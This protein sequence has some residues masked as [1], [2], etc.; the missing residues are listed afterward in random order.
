MPPGPFTINDLY[1]AGNGG[2][3]QVDIKE[4]DGASQVFRFP[5]R[6]YRCYSARVTRAMPSPRANT[7]A[8]TVSRKTEIFPEHRST[9]VCRLTGRCMA[10]PNWLTATVLSNLGIGKNMGALGALSMDVTHQRHSAR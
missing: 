1:A 4:T 8:A 6:Q 5:T 7:V 2:D 3:L 10:V 9:G